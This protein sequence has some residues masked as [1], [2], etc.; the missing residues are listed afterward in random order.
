MISIWVPGPL[1]EAV[2]LH[3]NVL[4]GCANQWGPLSRLD[5][6]YNSWHVC[7]LTGMYIMNQAYSAWL[8]QKVAKLR[9]VCHADKFAKAVR[10]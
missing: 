3:Q 2:R 6:V 4:L 7:P 1:E 9:S 5:T 8:R 10:D